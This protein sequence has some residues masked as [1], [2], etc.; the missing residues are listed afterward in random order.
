MIAGVVING[1]PYTF[2][3][4][5]NPTVKSS[6]YPGNTNVLYYMV[7]SNQSKIANCEQSSGGDF[8]ATVKLGQCSSKVEVNSAL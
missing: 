4:R 3:H 7:N 6:M 5:L 2:L 8:Q 1:F